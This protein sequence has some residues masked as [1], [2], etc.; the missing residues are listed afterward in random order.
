[1]GLPKTLT[2]MQMKFAY[3]LVSN[4]GRKTKTECAIDAGYSKDAAR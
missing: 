4:E 1:M 3:E 2:E